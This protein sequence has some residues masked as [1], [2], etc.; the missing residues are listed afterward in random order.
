MTSLVQWPSSV[1]S[2]FSK[3]LDGPY[4]TGRSTCG[5]RSDGMSCLNGPVF[6]CLRSIVTIDG[7]SWMSD[8][9][10]FDEANSL[11]LRNT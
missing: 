11:A 4:W 1:S 9:G 6:D 10:R 8:R 3:P 2:Q 5:L 7:V